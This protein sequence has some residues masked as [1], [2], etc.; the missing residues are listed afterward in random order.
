MCLLLKSLDP[1]CRVVPHK[2]ACGDRD[3]LDQDITRDDLYI[4]LMSMKNGK[5]LGM[6]RFPYEFYKSM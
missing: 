5:S 1:C 2:V 4:A 3:R 6:D